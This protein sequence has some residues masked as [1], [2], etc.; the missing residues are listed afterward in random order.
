MKHSLL[1]ALL[2]VACAATP[3]LNAQNAADPA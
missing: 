3:L 1:F 2:F